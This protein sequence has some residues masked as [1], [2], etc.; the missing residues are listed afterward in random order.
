MQEKKEIARMRARKWYKDNHLRGLKTRR[1]YYKLNREKLVVKKR[2]YYKKYKKKH[3]IQAAIY[4]RTHRKQ[5][6][7]QKKKWYLKNKSRVIKK[8]AAYIKMRPLERNARASVAR[9]LTSGKLKKKSCKVCGKKKVQAH[10]SDY[11]KPLKVTWFCSEHHYQQHRK[12][13][14]KI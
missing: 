14:V 8:V 2:A 3:S 5:V 4:R 13:R 7:L 11:L 6:S 10:H 9:A 12:I 1:K